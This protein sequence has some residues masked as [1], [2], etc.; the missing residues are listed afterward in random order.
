M[1]VPSA[2][3]YRLEGERLNVERRPASREMNDANSDRPYDFLT[4]KPLAVCFAG[5]QNKTGEQLDDE[6][7]REALP[8]Q[9]DWARHR[10]GTDHLPG[11]H[12]VYS[13]GPVR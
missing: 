7:P 10:S 9:E 13:K 4:S 11:V 1:R 5:K 3:K 12:P 8:H 6:R 2:T